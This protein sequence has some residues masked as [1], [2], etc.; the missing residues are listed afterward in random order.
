MTNRIDIHVPALARVE[1]EGAL[2]L[3]VVDGKI[4][5]LH[6]R[7]FE[8]PRLFEKFLEGRFATEIPD[9]VAR[10]CGIC[11]VAY[12]MSGVLA[13]EDAFGMQVTPWVESMRRLLYTGEWIESHALHIHLLALPDFLGAESA[14]DLAK[15]HPDVL[16]RGVTLQGV[17]NAIVA[18]LGG[19]SVHPVGVAV[20][21][22]HKAPAKKDAKTLLL[23]IEEAIPMAED[24]LAFV[25]SLD[26]PQRTE[27]FTSLAV[28][29]ADRY[30]VMGRHLQASTGLAFD[31]SHIEQHIEEYQ[32]PH[33]TAFY[34]ML[35]GEPFL[36]GPLARVNINHEQLRPQIKDALH[37][38]GIA[39][40]MHN[41]FDSIKARAAEILQ[42]LLEAQEIL[43][44]YEPDTPK[45]PY[46]PRA[47]TGFGAS[48]AP[49]GL[50]WHRYDF[51][52]EG[53]VKY[54]KI[55][56]PTSQNQAMIEKD[57]YNSLNAFGFDK[58]KDAIRLHAESV[59]RNY[60][61]CISCATH[62]LQVNLREA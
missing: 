34:A 14:F 19:R 51:D 26:L 45:V 13:I 58:D 38:H 49:R 40:P 43:Q 30:G 41:I 44:D 60:D 59:I 55:V 2:D 4:E 15:T 47:A 24:L 36:V 9:M 39:L 31:V 48:E 21:G 52:K 16:R 6:L 25:A 32:V 50:L 10:I 3:E 12:Q 7:I 5:S 28:R 57:L 23:K 17:G 37:K 8:P 35:E 46:T 54:A 18:F 42:A 33:S 20:G 53:R 11:P 27:S 62:F 29:R 61:P 56:P 22:F 1:G